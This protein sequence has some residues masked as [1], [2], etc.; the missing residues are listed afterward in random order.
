MLEMARFLYFML[1]AGMLMI[2]VWSKY[3]S[4]SEKFYLPLLE[5]ALDYWIL[6]YQ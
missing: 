5:N 4:G 1:M 6:S 3:L 2:K